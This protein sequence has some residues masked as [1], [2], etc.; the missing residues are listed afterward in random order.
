MGAMWQ[1][2]A[3]RIK[4]TPEKVEET[5]D[6]DEVQLTL[7]EPQNVDGDAGHRAAKHLHNPRLPS[8][9]EAE[10]HYASGHLPYRSWCNHCMRGRGREADDR[11]NDKDAEE[12]VPEYYMAYCFPGNDEDERLTVL[13][14]IERHSRM[15]K[16]A[17]VPCKGSTGTYAAKMILDSGCDRQ[18]GLGSGDQV[19]GGR[20]LQ[21]ED[22]SEDHKRRVCCQ[23][24]QGAKW[25]GREGSANR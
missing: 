22:R 9:Q 23:E 7:E 6:K 15:K 18:D 20:H 3:N 10:Q 25:H 4:K 11:R 12:G 16:A 14:R 17:V 19:L 21:D 1:E 2:L 13:V 8:E 5:V 24:L